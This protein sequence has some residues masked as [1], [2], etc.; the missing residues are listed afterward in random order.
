MYN[1][2]RLVVLASVAM[3]FIVIV[4]IVSIIIRS[5][6]A[7][8]VVV[9]AGA[10]VASLVSGV[11]ALF[12]ATSIIQ[13][14]MDRLKEIFA[15]FRE[16]KPRDGQRQDEPVSL[17]RTAG[18]PSITRSA[19][20]GS[21]QPASKSSAVPP[22]RSIDD[23]VRDYRWKLCEDKEMNQVRIFTMTWSLNLLN[24]YVRLRLHQQTGPGG[25]PE[26]EVLN[27]QAM[28]DPNQVF[29]AERLALERKVGKAI[30]PEQALRYYQ[31]C[32]MLGDPGVGK[33]TMLKY[34]ALKCAAEELRGLSNFPIF[35]DLNV[36]VQQLNVATWELHAHDTINNPLLVFA[37][38]QWEQRYGFPMQDALSYMHERLK[39]GNALVLLDGLDETLVGESREE[40]NRSYRRV[41]LAI[42]HLAEVYNSAFI[43]VTAR[44]AGY[45]QHVPLQE[46]T[47]LEVLGFRAND[48]EQFVNKWY[49]NRQQEQAHTGDDDRNRSSVPVQG[50]VGNLIHQLNNPQLQALASTPLL[51]ALMVFTYQENT[52]VLKQ[53]TELYRKCVSLLLE[54]WDRD[55]GHTLRNRGRLFDPVNKERLLMKVAWH[56]HTLGRRYFSEED[57]LKIIEDYLQK[58]NML[59]N[60]LDVL[61]E[62]SIGS[63]LLKKM[64]D[65]LYGFLHLTLQE[66][67]VA[68]EAVESDYARLES[69][70]DDPWWAE[71][72]VLYAGRARDASS[73]L[74][75]LWTQG[76]Y[77]RFNEGLDPLFHSKL[78]LAGRC[79]A[80][81][82]HI[83]NFSLR[84]KITGR[85]QRELRNTRYA[86]TRQQLAETLAALG[87][88]PIDD[89]SSGH[90]DRQSVWHKTVQELLFE[91][92]TE[93]DSTRPQV[94][95]SIGRALA[96]YGQEEAR[97]ELVQYLYNSQA[98]IEV[99]IQISQALG[100]CGSSEIAHQLV[101]ALLKP[102]Y[103]VPLDVRL[104]I[105]Q[106]LSDLIDDSVVPRL[107]K[108]LLNRKLPLQLRCA[109]V[110]SLGTSGRHAAVPDLLDLCQQDYSESSRG[111]GLQ[112]PIYWR[113]VVALASLGENLEDVYSLLKFVKD[114]RS[115][116]SGDPRREIVNALGTLQLS[117]LAQEM[118][119]LVLDEK[120]DRLV[121]ISIVSAIG[122]IGSR[123]LITPI[124]EVL[125]NRAIDIYVR[126]ALCTTVGKLGDRRHIEALYRVQL[127]LTDDDSLVY[128]SITIARG[129]LG[130]KRVVSE[131]IDYLT[132]SESEEMTI[133]VHLDVLDAIGSLISELHESHFRTMLELVQRPS[134]D[135]EI[136]RSVVKLLP[137]LVV[138]ASTHRF[139]REVAKVLE[140]IVMG[141]G[142][143]GK[144]QFDNQYQQI[145]DAAHYAYWS[146]KQIVNT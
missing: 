72:L 83:E 49:F 3:T 44:F 36:F 124:L 146:V 126:S 135:L 116:A 2:R 14:L 1:S 70:L 100:L 12:Y 74:E 67:F 27:A 131:L 128:R 113:V 123:S 53:R 4:I 54:E 132:Q 59:S 43:V 91:L 114:E 7:V 129:R 50:T 32:V 46:F 111:S 69:H 39:D 52:G 112:F 42:N 127:H 30:E 110:E 55:P 48:I 38:M 63:G 125:Q 104:S 16:A 90:I 58:I 102:D 20:R 66:Y 65:G 45:Q 80:V 21:G 88:Q 94:Q 23:Y 86:W 34:L 115:P 137:Q 118:F 57:L 84:M 139:K 108:L 75:D 119:P 140:Q 87:D 22:S 24:I 133:W 15:S 134:I 85:L 10:L 89:L 117:S 120:I 6:A 56:F 95:I 64:G 93:H 78:I 5:T 28:R 122:A 77:D 105:A 61:D 19:S 109:I 68:V 40:A 29:R 62:I 138:S 71:V 97:N 60:P 142:E 51:L 79:L 25:S 8:T 17:T 76:G 37:A 103:V 99:Q 81:H 35:I 11:V 121:R 107:V 141:S 9:A 98:N 82:P 47:E 106:S 31:R 136:K 92:L 26:P 96:I 130:D 145:V 41:E 144:E 73:L 18:L 143:D 101:D 13:T 33:T